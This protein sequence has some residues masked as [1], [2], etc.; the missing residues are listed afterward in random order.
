MPEL[1]RLLEHLRDFLNLPLRFL[2]PEVDRRADARRAHVERL[3]DAGEADLIERVR[4]REELVV[5][6]LEDERNLVRV[7]PRDRSEHAERRRDGVAAAFDRELHDV[8]GIE[9]RRVRRERRAG[10]MLD[11][12]ID[13]QDRHVAGAGQP[14]VIEQ[15]LQAAE[16]ARRSIRDAI[17]ALDEVGPGQVQASPSE[18]SCTDAGAARRLRLRGSLRAWTDSLHWP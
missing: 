7:L 17:D 6:E 12:L 4:I 13:R 9:V 1:V 3:L 8:L 18:S 15:R 5:I 11:A 10:R 16:H 14:A 2:G